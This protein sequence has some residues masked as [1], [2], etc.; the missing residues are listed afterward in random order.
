M[1]K[2]TKDEYLPDLREI[3]KIFDSH[4]A[5]YH[6]ERL[7]M[8]ASEDAVNGLPRPDT[9]DP[10]P[11]ELELTHAV[12]AVANR[13]AASFRAALE[14]LDA[15][16]KGEEHRMASQHRHELE[17]INR[18]YAIKA[19]ASE[20]AFGLNDAHKQFGKA[21][22]R[23][24]QMYDKLG[25]V[26]VRY[27]PH[28]LYMIFALAI[29]LGEIPLN[30]L[31]FQIFGENQVMTWVMAFVIGLSVPLTAHFIGIKLREHG[32]GFSIGNFLKAFS[33]F[34]VITIA[35]YGLSL[36]RQTY[37]GEF[38]T[39]LGLTDLLVERSFLFFWLNMAVFVS[40]IIVSYLAHDAVPGFESLA[41]E[42]KYSR[43]SVAKEERKRVSDLVRS[44]EQQAEALHQANEKQRDALMEVTMWKGVY[45][46]VLKEGQAHEQ[47]C[48]D[49][50]GL[51]LSIYR[52]ENLRKRSDGATPPSFKIKPDF[53]LQLK[54]LREKLDNDDPLEPRSNA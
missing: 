26:P 11:F 34:A 54:H 35:L 45:D 18:R 41:Q 21:E 53:P 48:L 46:Q 8:R 40:A 19:D 50:L 51:Q 15:R 20:N 17:N 24:D 47:R 42:H 2:I 23:Y 9:A 36:M 5:T 32:D 13:V 1:K 28:W 7:R 39:E 29:F 6:E 27:V 30:A 52:H 38:K 25:R 33:V 3:E 14:I 37:L 44:S 49:L 12:S 10:S 31:V 43:K 16:I 4:K 22:Q